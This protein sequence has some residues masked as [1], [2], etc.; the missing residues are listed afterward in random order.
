MEKRITP[1]N[2]IKGYLLFKKGHVAIKSGGFVEIRSE[3][4][5]NERPYIMRTFEDDLRY[6]HSCGALAKNPNILCKHLIAY[7]F[8][9]FQNLMLPPHEKVIKVFEHYRKNKIASRIFDKDMELYGL[10][11]LG[12]PEF[13]EYLWL[14]LLSRLTTKQ[15]PRLNKNITKKDYENLIK[16]GKYLAAKLKSLEDDKKDP[17]DI[18]LSKCEGKSLGDIIVE[19]EEEGIT[20]VKAIIYRAF[21][22]G[23]LLPKELGK[24]YME[25]YRQYSDLSLVL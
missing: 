12:I 10:T 14:C 19:G 17:R 4:Y 23:L 25:A 9:K 7:Q 8:A 15:F 21:E 22:E 3:R 6:E 18:V 2:Y 13:A 16:N 24:V 11:D 5:P 20:N 1:S